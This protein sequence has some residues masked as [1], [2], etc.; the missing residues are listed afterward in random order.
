LVVDLLN[1]ENV[2]SAVVQRFDLV[3]KNLL[4]NIMSKELLQK[5]K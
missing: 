5:E 4:Q 1:I 3:Q 2:W